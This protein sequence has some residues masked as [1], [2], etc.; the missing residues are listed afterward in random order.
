MKQIPA[1]YFFFII[2]CCVNLY[3]AG[4]WIMLPGENNVKGYYRTVDGSDILEYRSTFVVDAKIEVV[5][6]FLRHV[7]G[8]REDN[9]NCTDLRFIDWKD[10]NNCILYIA[11]SYSGPLAGRDLIVKVTTA[12]DFD[13]G[14]VISDLAALSEPLVPLKDGFVRITDYRAQYVI[15]YINKDKTGVIFT[16]RMNPGDSIPSFIVNYMGKRSIFS[17]AEDIRAAVKKRKYIEAGNNSK[18]VRVL[19][20]VFKSRDAMKIILQKRMG[21]YIR[22]DK[23]VKLFT[24]NSGMYDK[25]CRGEGEIGEVILNS[26][27]PGGDRKKA[28]YVLIRQYLR[29][30]IDDEKKVESFIRDNDLV[31]KAL[32]GSGS[33]ELVMS[34]TGRS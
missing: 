4:E 33:A 21:E 28:L 13:K 31:S 19:E 14:R 16:T 30:Y 12:Y 32:Y 10:N 5:G 26:W 20:R 6:A 7:D 9:R 11:Y 15:E 22:D 18:E 8:L 17:S 2:F 25:L 1:I 29:Q 24:N 27:G 3:A 23:L 34:F